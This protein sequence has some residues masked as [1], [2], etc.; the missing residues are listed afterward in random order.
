[1]E[2]QFHQAKAKVMG[3]DQIKE[4]LHLRIEQADEKLLTVLDELAESL[5]K[6]YQPDALEQARQERIATYEANL[7]PMTKEELIA[8][9]LASQADIEAGRIHD[10]EEVKAS[11]GL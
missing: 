8:R 4:R 10:L 3:I 11:L 2:L 7:K 6:N 9:A 5:F 1:M